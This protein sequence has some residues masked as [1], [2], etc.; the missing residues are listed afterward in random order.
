MDGH[1]AEVLTAPC[2]P[3]QLVSQRMRFPQV[4]SLIVRTSPVIPFC[5]GTTTPVCRPKGNF[6]RINATLK[7]GVIHDTSITTSVTSA[8]E[9][10]SYPP[11]SSSTASKLEDMSVSFGF[12]L[13]RC[14]LLSTFQQF[15]TDV[16]PSPPESLKMPES[17]P[18]H[19]LWTPSTRPSSF[20][21]DTI[22]LIFPY[23]SSIYPFALTKTFHPPTPHADLLAVGH[24]NLMSCH[25]SNVRRPPSSVAVLHLW[26]DNAALQDAHVH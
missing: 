14:S 23:S 9:I 15:P 26:K 22:I 13:P 1:C 6:Y 16:L 25:L 5:N 10:G 3:M 12:G 19:P 20:H 24:Y 18:P 4:D 17:H 21:M 2:C 7:T 8:E 11:E